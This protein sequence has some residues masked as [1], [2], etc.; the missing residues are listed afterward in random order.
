MTGIGGDWLSRGATR[1]QTKEYSQIPAQRKD[2]F[3]AH[4]GEMHISQMGAHIRIPFIGTY[5][6][7]TGLGNR[8]VHSR[9]RYFTGQEF[10]TQMFARSPG[11]ELRIGIPFRRTQMFMERVLRSPLSFFLWIQG[12]TI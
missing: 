1:Q 6:E 7:F 4:T 10:F 9:D 5:H 2:F 12:N 3:N 8:E 11:Q